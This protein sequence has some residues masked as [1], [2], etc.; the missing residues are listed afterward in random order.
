MTPERTRIIN[1]LKVEEYYWYNKFVVYVNNKK[2]DTSFE[3]ACLDLA[4]AEEAAK[5]AIKEKSHD[6]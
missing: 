1:G 4:K 2:V 3:E 5:K 6:T